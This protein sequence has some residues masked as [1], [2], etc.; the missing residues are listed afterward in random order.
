MYVWTARLKDIY[1]CI[2]QVPYKYNACQYD[3]RH[4][5][6]DLQSA[7]RTAAAASLPQVEAHDWLFT[8]CTR[9]VRRTSH[10]WWRGRM[11]N[12]VAR[13]PQVATPLFHFIFTA[14]IHRPATEKATEHQVPPVKVAKLANPICKSTSRHSWSPPTNAAKPQKEKWNCGFFC[15]PPDIGIMV[16]GV[17]YTQMPTIV[18]HP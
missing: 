15:E 14:I 2:F 5:S 12:S 7:I 18:V 13:T 4:K 3:L 8:S 10:C 17:S 6:G 11:F 1:E 9:A 16:V